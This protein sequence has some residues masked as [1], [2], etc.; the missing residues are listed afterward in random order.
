MNRRDLELLSSYLDG[1][2]KPSDSARLESRLSADPSLRA[3]LDDLRAARGLLRQL[4]MRKAPRDF[5]LTPKMV[6]KNPPLPSA[7]S[8]FRFVTTLATVLL[9]FT[10][11]LNFL[12]PQMASQEPNT[13]FGG[14]G[15]PEVFSAQAPAATEAAATEAPAA[16]PAAELVPLPTATIAIEDTAR[17]AVTPLAR[18]GE[19]G[20]AGGQ[21]SFGVQNIPPQPVPPAWQILLAGI[22]LLGAFI[23]VMMRRLTANRWRRK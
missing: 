3:V 16:E 6:G 19:A 22:A 12:A 23:M 5:R 15:A 21:D 4:P 7:Y 11:G 9:F 2:L 10:V 18:E 14:G 1:Q 13:G 20:D 8:A 17:E